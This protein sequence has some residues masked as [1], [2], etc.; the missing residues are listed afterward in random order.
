MTH[1]QHTPEALHPARDGPEPPGRG[2]GAGPQG[3]RAAAAV[4]RVLTGE[5]ESGGEARVK[6]R[7]RFAALPKCEPEVI[8]GWGMVPLTRE[9]MR[10]LASRPGNRKAVATCKRLIR[11]YLDVA[12]RQD[13]EAVDPCI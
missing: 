1:D 11:V 12:R 8:D 9:R 5:M 10:S 13:F 7:E 4:V 2:G 3:A 6:A